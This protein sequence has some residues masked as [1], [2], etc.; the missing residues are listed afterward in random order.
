M[1]RPKMY[2]LFGVLGV[3][4]V[5]VLL[6]LLISGGSTDDL[7]RGPVDLPGTDSKVTT[8]NAWNQLA[9]RQESGA[10]LVSSKRPPYPYIPGE[11]SEP[12]CLASEKLGGVNP[13]NS[14][15]PEAL[16]IRSTSIWRFARGRRRTILIPVTCTS[17]GTGSPVLSR[18]YPADLSRCRG[19]SG[20]L[21]LR[22]VGR[23]RRGCGTR[24]GSGLRVRPVLVAIWIWVC[25][26]NLFRSR[27]VRWR[28][29]VLTGPPAPLLSARSCARI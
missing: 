28:A 16:R 11:I 7:N 26:M 22:W 10:E 21:M 19:R 24:R 27:V 6:V 23:L 20:L 5:A 29:C 17:G 2:R 18:R 8:S 4:A 3:V 25:M 14:W 9:S 1:R 15:G 12:G 13:T